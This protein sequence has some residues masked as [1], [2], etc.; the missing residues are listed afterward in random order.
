MIV[1]VPA[2]TVVK[3]AKLFLGCTTSLKNIYLKKNE[4]ASVNAR[5]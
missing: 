1:V 4:A 3:F 5:T 2:V